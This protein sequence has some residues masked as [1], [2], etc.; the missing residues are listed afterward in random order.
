MTG[1]F[2]RKLHKPVLHCAIRTTLFAGFWTGLCFEIAIF[3]RCAYKLKH[4]E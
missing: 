2:C 1:A 4:K 3:S